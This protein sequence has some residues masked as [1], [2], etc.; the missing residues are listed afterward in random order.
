MCDVR[1]RGTAI[2]AQIE[3]LLIA[4]AVF[5]VIVGA[6]I[7]SAVAQR[8]RPRIVYVKAEALCKTLAK[9]ILPAIV[10]HTLRVIHVVRLPQIWIGSQAG[11]TIHCVHG[12]EHREFHAPRSHSARFEHSGW[13]DLPL[14]VQRVLHRV[15]IL[16]IGVVD[17]GYIDYR[18]TLS[19]LLCIV[20]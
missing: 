6:C 18:T 11:E 20:K 4:A 1:S 15:R 9:R 17:R 8:L 13:C 7:S 2:G 14:N 19:K 3:E 16:E 12:P 10:R 5:T